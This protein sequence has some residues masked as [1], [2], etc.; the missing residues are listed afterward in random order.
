MIDF[1]GMLT[2]LELFHARWLQNSI[3]VSTTNLFAH[4]YFTQSWREKTET[5]T[6]S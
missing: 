3:N 4:L 1:N 2:R 5:P 6:L